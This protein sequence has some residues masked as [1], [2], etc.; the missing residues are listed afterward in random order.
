MVFNHI[1]DLVPLITTV[2]NASLG[3]GAV[4]SCFK[5]AS[6]SPLLK[7]PDLDPDDM[8]NYRPLSNLPFLSKVL[9]KIV[10]SQLKYHLSKNELVEPFQSAYRENHSTGTALLRICCDLLNDADDGLI[11]VLS[12]LDLSAAFGTLDHNIMLNRLSDMFGLSG[13]VLG[14][15]RSYL[16]NR[17]FFVVDEGK[18]SQPQLLGFGVPQGSV[19]GPVLYTMY[20]SPLGN[21]IKHHSMPYHMYAAD[22]QLYKSTKANRILSVMKDTTECSVSVKAWMIQN[23]L[24]FND[25]KTDIIPCSTSTKINTLDVDHVIIGNSTITF[26]KKANNLGVFDNDLSMESRRNDVCKLS[27]LELRRLAHL[28]PYLNMDAMKKLVSAF[29]L[30]RLDYCTSLF[31]G[32][33]NNDKITNFQRIRLVL[34]QPKRHHISPLHKDLHWLPI[35]ARIDYKVALL[36]FKCLNNNAPVYI[37]DLFV[38]YPPARQHLVYYLKSMARDHSH[39]QELTF[40]VLLKDLLIQKVFAVI[41]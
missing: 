20:P 27:Y 18:Q 32:L 17:S 25:A 9:E 29:V 3:E 26:S 31:A 24:K 16:C 28:I 7:K 40:G 37:K 14:W 38:P 36:C 2:V 11:S 23:K 39:F 10:L 6:V 13:C 15:F 30:S 4:P 34:K 41:D 35:K 5:V 33:S 22:T 12:L 21:S 1:D 19:L 8:K